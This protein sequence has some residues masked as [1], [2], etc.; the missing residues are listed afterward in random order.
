MTLKNRTFK[1]ALVVSLLLF[2]SCTDAI[3]NLS[4][5][6]YSAMDFS[7]ENLAKDGIV[8]TPTAPG[9]GTREEVATI[10]SFL[11]NA[12]QRKIP[13]HGL[14]KVAEVTTRLQADKELKSLWEKI[15]PH[16]SAHSVRGTEAARSFAMKLH[17]R[18][19]L[20]TEIQMAEVAGGAEQVRV[21]GRIF[22][23][24]RDRTVWE[25]VGEGRGYET[26][27]FPSTPATFRVIAETAVNGLVDRLYGH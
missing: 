26:L 3:N 6:I 5:E 1:V 22:D 27:V 10:C 9:D 24:K 16:I 7:P 19:L 12:M 21:Y 20:E 25:G 17:V 23:A 4:V 2:S 8:L 15:E 14:I 11:D 18:Y 13:G